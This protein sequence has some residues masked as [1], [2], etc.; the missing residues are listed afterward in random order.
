MGGRGGGWYLVEDE[1][2]GFV[3]D[4][5]A[6]DRRHGEAPREIGIEE[7]EGGGDLFVINF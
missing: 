1:A 5:E 7:E 2:P 3:D 6:V 4:E